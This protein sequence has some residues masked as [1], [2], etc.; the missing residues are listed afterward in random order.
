LVWQDSSAGAP[1]SLL[2]WS[3]FETSSN[4]R[5]FV[6][7][8]EGQL[9]QLAVS[10]AAGAIAGGA[11]VTIGW[12][13][14]SLWATPVDD[15]EPTWLSLRPAMLFC[16]ERPGKPDR[17]CVAT[18]G[19]SP[20]SLPLAAVQTAL[21]EAVASFYPD[22]RHGVA[23]R[24]TALLVRHHISAEEL[25]VIPPAVPT[26]DD[27]V[28]SVCDDPAV[29][30]AWTLFD[31]ATPSTSYDLAKARLEAQA[32]AGIA[33]QQR[34]PMRVLEIDD[35]LLPVVLRMDKGDAPAIL[36]WMLGAPPADDHISY[37]VAGRFSLRRLYGEFAEVVLAFMLREFPHGGLIDGLREAARETAATAA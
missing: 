21:T 7:W 5:Y 22:W 26:A 15:L 16:P 31:R 35:Y 12:T 17:W 8:R 24:P 25:G 11:D 33:P 27:L 1:T 37:L 9:G 14:K 18:D 30:Q 28:N 3:E 36:A 13:E 29:R 19:G 32:R 4:P 6:K 34:A 20:Q 23:W 2:R 10:A